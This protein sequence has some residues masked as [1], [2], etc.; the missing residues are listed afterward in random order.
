MECDSGAELSRSV[1]VL[2]QVMLLII[3]VAILLALRC[4]C[5]GSF[6]APVMLTRVLV[7]K[8]IIS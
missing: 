1:D 6:P 5:D 3:T 4:K 2:V 8:K 7:M